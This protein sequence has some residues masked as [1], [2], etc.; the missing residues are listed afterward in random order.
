M[1]G[2]SICIEYKDY[3]RHKG[4]WN[5]AIMNFPVETLF[6]HG[7]GEQLALRGRVAEDAVY[8]DSLKELPTDH[9]LVLLA[10]EKCPDIKGEEPLTEFVHPEKAVYYFGSNDR[11]TLPEH[12]A[13]RA[14]DHSVYIDLAAHRDMWS[15]MAWAIVA[16]D[17]ITKSRRI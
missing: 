8:V 13:G 2:V 5:Y 11:A 1:M 7:C 12:F 6:V 16:Y 9:T 15:W 14:H 10:P 4:Q 3:L 17:Q